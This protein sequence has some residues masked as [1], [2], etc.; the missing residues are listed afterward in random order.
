[1]ANKAKKYAGGKENFSNHTASRKPIVKKLAA[2]PNE[3]AGHE[4]ILL[5][6]KYKVIG[7][8]KLTI[9]CTIVQRYG[10]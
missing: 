1:M 2:N 10:F 7:M 4:G 6:I 5:Y 9:I 3:N 8:D